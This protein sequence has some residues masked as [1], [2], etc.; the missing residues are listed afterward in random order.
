MPDREALVFRDRRL[1]WA[2]LTERTRRLANHLHAAGL[3]CHTERDR[4]G[5]RGSPARTTSPSTATTATS[6]S[7][8]CSARSR[9][10]WRRSTSTTATWPRSCSTCSPT[11]GAQA[12]VYH[13][14]V[15]ARRS[16]RCATSCPTCELLLQVADDSGHA[17]AARGRLVRGRAGRRPGRAAAGR[18]VARRP[19]HPLHRRHHRHAQGRAVAPG[20]HLHGVLRRRRRDRHRRWTTIVAAAARRRLQRCP[21]RRSCTAPATG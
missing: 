7:R 11:P 2:Q 15:R 17:A 21:R 19:L 16:P 18:A 6:T 13:S 12:I 3:G 4:A 8:A 5:A 20:R 10:G 14:R 9:R 1:T